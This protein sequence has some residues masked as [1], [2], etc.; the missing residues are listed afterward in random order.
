MN[1][2]GVFDRPVSKRVGGTE[3]KRC[4]DT[5]PGHPDVNPSGLWS[6]PLA[7]FWNVGMR[8]NSLQKTTRVSSSRPRCLR[9]ASSPAAG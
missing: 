1:T 7:P 3:G 2:G 4:P 9:S 8:P 5:C 6:R